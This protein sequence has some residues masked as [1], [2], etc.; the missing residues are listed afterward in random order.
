MNIPH[1]GSPALLNTLHRDMIINAPIIKI[2]SIRIIAIHPNIA[3]AI[4]P[5]P[6]IASEL[7][8][9]VSNAHESSKEKFIF[10]VI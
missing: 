3:A 2:P 1:P 10:F 4:V 6:I 7:I 5:I 9:P 8:F